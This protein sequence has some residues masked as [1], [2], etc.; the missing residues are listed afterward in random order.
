MKNS[1]S[2]SYKPAVCLNQD[3]LNSFL[4]KDSWIEIVADE[5]N[6]SLY[7]LSFHVN[8]LLNTCLEYQNISHH[9]LSPL[10]THRKVFERGRSVVSDMMKA[11]IHNFIKLDFWLELSAGLKP[12][13]DIFSSLLAWFQSIVEQMGP[14]TVKYLQIWFDLSRKTWH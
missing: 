9:S 12:G 1:C 6:Y 10:S 14:I 5:K 8:T 4:W 2:S 13:L 7:L 11:D 3:K